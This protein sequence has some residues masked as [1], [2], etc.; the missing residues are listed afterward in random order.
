MLMQQNFLET[1]LLLYFLP[2]TKASLIFC[3]YLN[4]FNRKRSQNEG[5]QQQTSDSWHLAYAKVDLGFVRR[6]LDTG[7]LLT[8][9][10]TKLKSIIKFYLN[11][12]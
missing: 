3:S 9:G 2:Q 7:R 6:I 4:K 1:L 8:Q 12:L 11:S 10:K 5:G